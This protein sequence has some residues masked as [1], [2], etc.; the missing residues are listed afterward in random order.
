MA[1]VLKN[2]NECGAWVALGK[3]S[4]GLE[5]SLEAQHHSVPRGTPCREGCGLATSM[6]VDGPAKDLLWFSC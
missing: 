6:P 3:I 2:M 1:L 5:A 4:G